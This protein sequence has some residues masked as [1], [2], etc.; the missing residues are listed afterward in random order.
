MN[1]CRPQRRDWGWPGPALIGFRF[2]VPCRQI[3]FLAMGAI[4]IGCWW[5]TLSSGLTK[6]HFNKWRII[7]RSTQARLYEH[8][9]APCH[10]LLFALTISSLLLRRFF[11]GID[12]QNHQVGTWNR[13][14]VIQSILLIFVDHPVPV[15]GSVFYLTSYTHVGSLPVQE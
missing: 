15:T 14:S 2:V 5:R 6:R 7:K 11:A 4:F 8:L 10:F 12:H 9:K 3:H 13:F 1:V